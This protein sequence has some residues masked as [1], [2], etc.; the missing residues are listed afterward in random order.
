MRLPAVRL[1]RPTAAPGGQPDG[2]H[3]RRRRRWY[4]RR[5]RRRSV[6]TW[7]RDLVRHNTGLKVV[8]LLL[9]SFVWYSI[10]ELERDAE[11]L[12]EVQVAIRKVPPDLMV[13]DLSPATG[14]TVTLRGPRTILDSVDPEKTRL[15]V[16][17]STAR[18][19]MTEVDLNR[20]T[21]APELPRRLKAVRMSP[22]RLKARLEPVKKLRLPVTASLA[23]APA[24]GYT[25]KATV[26]PDHVEVMG[27]SSTLGT[28]REISTRRIDVDGQSVP[29]QRNIL[30]EPA[31]DFVTVVPDRVRVAVSFTENVGSQTFE[32]VPVA[33]RNGRASRIIPPA[34]TLTV[35][36]PER[37]L[38]QLERPDGAV[39]VDAGGLA[40]GTHE[41]PVQVDLPAPLEVSKREPERVRVVVP[42]PE[43]QGGN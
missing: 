21:L 16:D 23:G 32:G 39:F 4:W 31:G 37:D 10:N 28:L 11:R 27:P 26:T 19:G 14:V 8:S 15:V 2:G 38:K 40:P 6:R 36:G 22:M 12:V 43:E 34:V 18:R 13:T 35:T 24:V 17:L 33:L 7:L 42:A 25:A 41:L 1:R 20:A 3:Q 5:V 9:A 29:F 30:V